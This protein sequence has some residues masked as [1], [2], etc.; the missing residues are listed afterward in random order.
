VGKR[1]QLT[2]AVALVLGSILPFLGKPVHVDD[3]NFLR[4]AEGAA[5]DPWRPHAIDINWLGVTEPAFDVLSNPPGIAYWL[6][7][8]RNLPEWAL[9]L[10]MLPWL[11]LALLGMRRLAHALDP[12]GSGAILVLASAPVF[13]LSAQALTPDLPLLA[14][15]LLGISG[16]LTSERRA[17]AWALLAGCGALFRY[18][19]LCVAPLLL[20]AG[21]ERKRA[22][23]ALAALAPAALLFLHDLDAYG[24]IHAVAMMG[25]QGVSF[26]PLLVFRKAVAFLATLGG[27][28]M[29]PVLAWRRLPGPFL[30]LG[31]AVLGL[32]ASLSSGHSL[33]QMAP[34]VLFTAAGAVSLGVFRLRTPE[35]RFL[36]AWFF[37]GFAFLLT[38]QFAA[39]RY[40]LL[41]L[42]ALIVAAL[43]ARPSGARLALAVAAGAAVSL[44]MAVDDQAFA[45]AYRDEAVAL[46]QGRSR[47]GY[48]AG[49]WGFQHYLER[50]EWK[51]LEAGT[52]PRGTLAVAWG[53][54]PQQPDPSAC[55]ERVE[56]KDL[57]DRWWGPRVH[58]A[59][60]AANY[61]SS[62]VSANPPVDTYAPWTFSDEPYDH[63]TV[64]RPCPAK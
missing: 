12:G 20:F 34:T 27:A 10:W 55:L 40:W 56:E 21:I 37:G 33:V 31:G 57:E 59:R 63:V 36:A 9:H 53:T 16:F 22:G 60:G 51:P 5:R 47:T 1:A 61:H 13:V 45:R 28:A 19:G 39:T 62:G 44:G 32:A 17:W 58:T 14:C 52:A 18:S 64:F 46:S 11:F 38:L 23:H 30:A 6:A 49:H 50:L 4:L 8:V 3:A 7:P 48:V 43:R 54:W 29:L 26:A 24:R 2:A 35:D 41:F 15:A 25:F 42:P